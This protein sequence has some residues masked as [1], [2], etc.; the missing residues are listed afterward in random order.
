MFH[1][2]GDE[3]ADHQGGGSSEV[4]Q[5]PARTCVGDDVAA[6][7]TA[8]GTGRMSSLMSSSRPF[9]AASPSAMLENTGPEPGTPFVINVAVVDY[10]A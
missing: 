10:G 5:V 1:R 4:R 8:P 2:V 3:F 9:S 6:R 7:R